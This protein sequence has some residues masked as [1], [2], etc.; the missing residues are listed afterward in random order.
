LLDHICCFNLCACSLEDQFSFH[1]GQACRDAKEKA[2]CRRVGIN[3][4]EKTSEVDSAFPKSFTQRKALLQPSPRG[5]TNRFLYICLRIRRHYRITKVLRCLFYGLL[6]SGIAIVVSKATIF[7]E[8]IANNISYITHINLHN[9]LNI[10]NAISVLCTNSSIYMQ[11]SPM[12]GTQKCSGLS[13]IRR[14]IAKTPAP[15][16]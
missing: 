7:M 10:L 15:C 9:I 4:V 6:F 5:S 1:F 3:I 11:P 2:P 8:H 16:F 14:E 12:S 13:R